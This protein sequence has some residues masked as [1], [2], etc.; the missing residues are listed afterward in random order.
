M[1]LTDILTKKEVKMLDDEAGIIIEDVEYSKQDIRN[2]QDEIIYFVM[3]H[4]SKNGDIGKYNKMFDS[5]LMTLG[6]IC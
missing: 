5:V 6:R 4:S 1:K 3:N 2:F